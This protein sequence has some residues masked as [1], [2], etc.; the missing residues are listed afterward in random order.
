MDVN[1]EINAPEALTRCCP[2]PPRPGPD[3]LRRFAGLLKALADPT[4]LDMVEL[5]A[6]ANGSL[7]VCDVES[8]FDL[9]QPTISHHLGLLRKAG[10]VLAERRG[11]WM[12][13]T[14]SPTGLEQVREFHRE[15]GASS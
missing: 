4:R 1:P 15:F 9:S 5:L 8:R 10:L 13:Y 7:C 11:T 2:P 6:R 12:H 3:G 14:L